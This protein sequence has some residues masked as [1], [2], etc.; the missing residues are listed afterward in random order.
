MDN[1]GNVVA[2]DHKMSETLN[3]FFASVFT[4]EDKDTLSRVKRCFAEKI[5]KTMHISH[6]GTSDMVKS[7]FSKLK[8]NKAPGI[9]LIGTRILI[10]LSE[11]ISDYVAELYNKTLRTSGEPD[12]WKL[13]NV[14]PVF[15]KGKK[16]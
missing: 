14:T 11:V 4:E 3:T 6:Y 2:G 15:K 8:M 7:K 12:D 16:N 9:D 10:E 1:Q 5:V 13:A